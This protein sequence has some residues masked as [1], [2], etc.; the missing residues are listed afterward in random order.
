MNIRREELL[1]I[2]PG[3]RSHHFAPKFETISIPYCVVRMI[4]PP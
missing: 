2:P 1:F 4:T 3:N